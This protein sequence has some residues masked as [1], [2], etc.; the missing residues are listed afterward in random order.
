MENGESHATPAVEGAA[1]KR[2]ALRNALYELEEAISSPVH[3]VDEWRLAVAE[4][5]EGLDGAFQD[6]VG[7]TERT[8][9][10]YD[11][12]EAM[13]HIVSKARRLRDEH[14]SLRRA[15]DEQMERFGAPFPADTDLAGFATTSSA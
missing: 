7:E 12:M 4:K 8:G 11:E 13:T 1:R 3:P 9:G 14:P 15:L 6:H 10:I 5:L 2:R